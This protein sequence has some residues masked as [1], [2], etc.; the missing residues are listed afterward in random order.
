MK[1]IEPKVEL[2]SELDITPESHI[3]RCARVYYGREYKDP[4]QEDDKK[5]V[6]DLVKRGRSSMLRHA[7]VYG[8]W[9]IVRPP[10]GDI[11]SEFVGT[12]RDGKGNKYA[13][14]NK[15]YESEHVLDFL[16]I[17]PGEF[18]E[19][20]I[21]TPHLFNIF[22]LTFCITTQISTISP[23]NIVENAKYFSS[24]DDLEICRPWWFNL[25]EKPGDSY[26]F[27]KS[28][29][30][31]EETCKAVLELGMKPEDAIG[32]LPLDTAIKVVYTHSVEKWKNILD[33]CAIEKSN[34]NA[35]LMIEKIR[36]E[37]NGF[38]AK[39]KINYNI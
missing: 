1:L 2:L 17:S 24:K 29:K 8:R 14:T 10:L 38:A 32:V 13:S 39:Y 28:W 19:S 34:P 21:K 9:W 16:K 33:Y 23:N 26:I 36:E 11:E 12:L 22:R 6:D 35:K 27:Y 20:A 37:I 3:A 25:K 15:Q 4:N 7:S 18:L 30:R 5:I 31:A